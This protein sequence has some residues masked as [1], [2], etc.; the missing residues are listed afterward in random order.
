MKVY[1]ITCH[2][3]LDAIFFYSELIFFLLTYNKISISTKTNR[4]LILQNARERMRSEV[5]DKFVEIKEETK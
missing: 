3:L 1:V 2:L 5:I 4:V